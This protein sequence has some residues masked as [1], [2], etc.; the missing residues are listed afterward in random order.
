MTGRR[1]TV[2]AYGSVEQAG[3][4]KKQKKKEWDEWLFY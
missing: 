1:L 3:K 2:T 4:A